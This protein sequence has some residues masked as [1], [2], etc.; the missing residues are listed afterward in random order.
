[1]MASSNGNIFRV[2]GPLCGE[3]TGPVN[4]PHKGQGRGALMFPLICAWIN[5]WVNNRET[6]DFRH[7][8]AHCDVNVICYWPVRLFALILPYVL[9]CTLRSFVSSEAG[10]SLWCISRDGFAKRYPHSLFTK[11]NIC[12]WDISWAGVDFCQVFHVFASSAH[13][14][15]YQR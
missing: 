12:L 1:M 13:A 9:T 3:Y 10:S 5:D 6:G 7:H 15:Q 8:R 14:S 11:K 2:T 4:S